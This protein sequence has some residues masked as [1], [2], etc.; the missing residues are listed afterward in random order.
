L[1]ELGFRKRC[2][3]CS[4][5][6]SHRIQLIFSVSIGFSKRPFQSSQLHNFLRLQA[7][8]HLRSW[9]HKPNYR[10]QI[11]LSVDNP[12]PTSAHF[13]IV[14]R[15]SKRC[16]PSLLRAFTVCTP[17][18]LISLAWLSRVIVVEIATK[19]TLFIN[20]DLKHY[21]RSSS[22]FL[23]FKPFRTTT[24]RTTRPSSI[25]PQFDTSCNYEVV[26]HLYRLRARRWH[27]GLRSTQRP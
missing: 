21:T 26:H 10:L 19:A 13:D 20:N 4:V 9:W 12:F 7:L 15:L 14:F 22:F 6:R 5:S 23:H 2:A 27:T 11:T 24:T 3:Q 1:Q 8:V 25:K 16:A 17:F 18:A